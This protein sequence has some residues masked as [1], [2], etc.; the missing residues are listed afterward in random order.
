MLFGVLTNNVV[1]DMDKPTGTPN[2]YIGTSH[3]SMQGGGVYIKRI[4]TDPLHTPPPFFFF[5]F[6]SYSFIYSFLGGV[7]S[8][9]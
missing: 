4:K 6:L 1:T 7:G 3:W 9:R 2:L 5:F 8:L